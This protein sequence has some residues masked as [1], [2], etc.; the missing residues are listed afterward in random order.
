M[1]Y[2]VVYET[3]AV[4][5]LAKIDKSQQAMIIAWIKKN[6]VNTVSP[7]KYGKALKGDLNEY[8]RYRIGDYRLI[9]N[10]IDNQITIIIINVDHRKKIYKD[11]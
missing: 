1:E 8:W 5:S 4:K 11:D 2:Q 9:V 3:R 7:R 6:L 10:I